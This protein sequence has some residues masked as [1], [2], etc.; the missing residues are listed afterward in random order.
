MHCII[1]YILRPNCYIFI[2]NV[3]CITRMIYMFNKLNCI[4]S[5]DTVV[6]SPVCFANIKFNFFNLQIMIRL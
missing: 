4:H 6:C 2:I 1:I 5:F 3:Y